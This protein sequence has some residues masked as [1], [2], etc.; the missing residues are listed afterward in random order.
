MKPDSAEYRCMSITTRDQVNLVIKDILFAKEQG[1]SE[2]TKPGALLFIFVSAASREIT[3]L[4]LV[5]AIT[6]IFTPCTAALKRVFKRIS[7]SRA[8]IKYMQKNLFIRESD[9]TVSCVSL[10]PGMLTG[11]APGAFTAERYVCRWRLERKF[12]VSK[13]TRWE[14]QDG[15]RRYKCGQFPAH[16][17][18]VFES[19]TVQ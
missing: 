11:S 16:A 7:P 6:G 8:V 15:V 4:S 18:K 17:R 3:W 14:K 1:V 9:F 12:T 5:L 13:I 2:V 19:R 10:K